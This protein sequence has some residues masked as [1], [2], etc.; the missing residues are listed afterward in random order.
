MIVEIP[1]WTN[2][3]LEINKETRFNPI[4]QDRA[5]DTLRFVNNLFP[6]KGYLWNYGA[7]PQTW[8]DPNR[9]SLATQ[10]RG[11]ND[12][13]DVIEIGD[14]VASVG[15]ILPVKIL[16][17]VALVDD[18]ETDWKVVV[19]NVRDPLAPKIHDITD[20]DTYKPGLLNATNHWFEMYKTPT[21]QDPNRIVFGGQTK[22]KTF[23][24]KVILDTHMSWKA[25]INGTTD[26]KNIQTINVSVNQSPY[27]V[28]PN[29]S[30]PP[31]TAQPPAPIDPSIDKWYYT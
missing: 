8:E 28:A 26:K 25:L 31:E 20:V 5:N 23:A 14:R 13:I 1:R 29:T 24:T 15:E 10:Y 22:N 11:D 12:P 30:L 4:M 2:A 7:F 16:G 27:R 18:N 21:G 9:I 6:Y 19:I 17:I 3:K